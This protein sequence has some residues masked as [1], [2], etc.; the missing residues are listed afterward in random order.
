[1]VKLGSGISDREVTEE[2]NKKSITMDFLS[3]PIKSNHQVEVE[4][5]TRKTNMKK[6][7]QM[8]ALV[9]REKSGRHTLPSHKP[10]G[11][12][13]G[14]GCMKVFEQRKRN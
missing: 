12:K 11:R 3:Q 10:G 7:M 1:M 9:E 4:D 8:V 6:N 14:G 2:H 13:G 5:K